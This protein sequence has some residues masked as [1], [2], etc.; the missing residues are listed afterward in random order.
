MKQRPSQSRHNMSLCDGTPS[1][2]R[3]LLGFLGDSFACAQKTDS[4]KKPV[5][6]CAA[7][8]SLRP[9]WEDQATN[10]KRQ[11]AT[12]KMSP[13]EGPDRTKLSRF[14]H[15][16]TRVSSRNGSVLT[17]ISLLFRFYFI[18]VSISSRFHFG[19]AS[20][21]ISSHTEVV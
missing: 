6:V 21:S 15:V 5:P 13:Y 17:L 2:F 11:T 8:L 20:I 10:N 19:L 12:N 3:F 1:K 16:Q 7:D 18:I 4:D 14:N 9:C